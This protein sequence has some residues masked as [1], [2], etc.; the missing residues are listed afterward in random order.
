LSRGTIR[1]WLTSI[2]GTSHPKIDQELGYLPEQVWVNTRSY[3]EKVASQ[4]NGCFQCGFY[5]AASVLVRRLIE[6]LI[7]E[8]YVALKRETEVTGGDG[9]FLM[10]NGLI[11]A[12][13]GSAP[14]GLGREGDKALR[15]VKELGDRSAHNRRF[16]AVKADLEKIQSGVRVMADELIAIARLRS[17]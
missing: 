8:A 2:L 3:V 6:T 5:D 12:A 15:A 16:V 9:H 1:E 13:I 17:S 10:L 7:I 4:M 11:N 14:I